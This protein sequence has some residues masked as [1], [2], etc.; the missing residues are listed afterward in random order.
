LKHPNL[1]YERALGAYAA[2]QEIDVATQQN[3]CAANQDTAEHSK[4]SLK[5]IRSEKIKHLRRDRPRS[6]ALV[7]RASPAS[8]VEFR[9]KNC[10]ALSVSSMPSLGFQRVTQ[11]TVLARNTG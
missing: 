10:V 4:I 9:L 8:I 11:S 3:I 2:N 5:P 6:D 1:S 7:L